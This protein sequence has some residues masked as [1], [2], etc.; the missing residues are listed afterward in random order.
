MGGWGG[1]GGSTSGGGGAPTSSKSCFSHRR[2]LPRLGV[3]VLTVEVM[4]LTPL[5]VDDLITLF[6][7]CGCQLFAQ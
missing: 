2:L 6:D 7:V 5:I 4:R 1:H 3:R